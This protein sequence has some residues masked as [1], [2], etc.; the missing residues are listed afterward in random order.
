M[1]NTAEG[2]VDSYVNPDYTNATYDDDHNPATPEVPWPDTYK[3]YATAN[4]RIDYAV[5]DIVHLL[6][7]LK[8]D[9]N[10]VIVYIFDIYCVIIRISDIYSIIMYND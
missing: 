3:R 9:S 6:E 4:R 2:K 5:G 10:T 1:I 7:D 8:I